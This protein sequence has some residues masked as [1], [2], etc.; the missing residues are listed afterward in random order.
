MKK[1]MLVI[2]AL[3]LVANAAWAKPAAV[4]AKKEAPA[5]STVSE[6][7][8]K[9]ISND[10]LTAAKRQIDTMTP[11]L[12][13]NFSMDVALIDMYNM[14]F[15][16]TNQTGNWYFYPAYR[17]IITDVFQNGLGVTADIEKPGYAGL[18]Y[19]TLKV[20]EL[21][22]KYKTGS[23]YYKLGRQVFGDKDDLILGMQADAVCFGFSMNTMDIPFF[24]AHT[25][26]ASALG[27]MDGTMGFVPVFKFSQDMGLRAYLVIETQPISVTP[28]GSTTSTDKTNMLIYLGAKYFMNLPIGSHGSFDLSAQPVVQFA[29]AQDAG[30]N[31]YD[32]TSMAFKGDAAFGMGSSDFGFK[33]GA[34]MVFAGGDPDVAVNTKA[35]FSS[36]NQLVG[37][38]PGA[39]SKVQDGAGPYTYVDSMGSTKLQQYQGV[40][41]FGLDANFDIL[42][43]MIQP[44]V[45]LWFYSDTDK[46]DNVKSGYIGTE[47]DET[48]VFNLTPNLAF[49]QQLGYM[50]PNPSY[51]VASGATDPTYGAGMKFV[52]G[53]K[54]SF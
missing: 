20:N 54:L 29:M 24:Y 17:G 21:Y 1:L 19:P 23:F 35:G 46:L 4:S 3:A 12:A 18:T 32:A 45:G 6:Y 43:K 14:A 52:L 26:L 47:I 36:P 48:V 30:A 22:G 2:T 39:F 25:D 37:S 40:F 49:Y 42:N 7:V 15:A 28:A 41:I 10:P 5:R 44:G 34:H 53:T 51:R 50:M 9:A 38:G 27:T 16:N 31:N 33:A 11:G 13:Y 8:P